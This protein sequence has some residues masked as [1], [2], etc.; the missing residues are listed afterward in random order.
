MSSILLTETN[1]AGKDGRACSHMDPQTSAVHAR[2]EEW[3]KWCRDRLNAW[4]QRTLLGRV[5][6]QGF[7]GAAQPGAERADVSEDVAVTDAAVARL[8]Q[9]DQRA[10]KAYYMRTEPIESSAKRV[11]MSK[12]MFQNVLRRARWRLAVYMGII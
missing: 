9:I 6:D 8:G 2:L 3:G 11:G 1:V 7:T 12:R 10:I 5:I 4:P